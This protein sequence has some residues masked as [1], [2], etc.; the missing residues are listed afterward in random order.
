MPVQKQT[1]K[2]V[3]INTK[4]KS[5][6]VSQ[7]VERINRVWVPGEVEDFMTCL[8]RVCII[9]RETVQREDQEE[10]AE[11]AEVAAGKVAA[12]GAVRRAI[13]RGTVPIATAGIGVAVDQEAMAEGEEATQVAQLIQ[14]EDMEDAIITDATVAVEDVEA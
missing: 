3:I 10:I 2:R 13:R 8:T 6:V 1:V 5:S 7:S 14:G 12:L 4:S 11:S 9:G